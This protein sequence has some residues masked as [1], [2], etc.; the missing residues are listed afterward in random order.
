MST[1][2][3]D[4]NNKLVTARSQTKPRQWRLD[5]LAFLFLLP[6]LA[7]YVVFTIFPMIKG[8]QMSLYDWTLIK[9]MDFVGLNNYMAM[10]QDANFWRALWNSTYFV[11]LSTPSML[12]FALLLAVIANQKTR[13]QKFFRSVFFLPSVLSVS[14]V[15]YVG[16][17]IIQPYTGFLNNLL[18]LV[19]I[20]SV[21]QEIF[22][23]TESSLA[24]IAITAITLWWTVGVNMILYLSAMQDIPDDIYEAGRLDGASERQMFFRIT[25]PLLGPITKTIL[26]LQIIAS[27]KVFLQIYIITRGGPGTDTRPIIQYIYE[28]GIKNNHMGYAAT[29]SY[30]LFAI[31]L[32]LSLTQL[33][34]S[35]KK[36]AV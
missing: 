34:M 33:K 31:L 19:G 30:A 23:L 17:F 8:L 36:E 13:L 11:I 5:I 15:S 26:L 1:K 10:V 28:E 27:Y 24:W 7:V 16:L 4:L 6:F 25:L 22:W 12:I 21:D 35:A 14:V 9:K 3:V 2:E 29:M 20:L 32:V 18:K